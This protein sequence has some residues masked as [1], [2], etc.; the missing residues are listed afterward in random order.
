MLTGSR[1]LPRLSQARVALVGA[2]LTIGAT[3]VVSPAFAACG[4]VSTS[5]N[6]G[7]HSASA[8]SGVHTG[9]SSSSTHSASLSSCPTATTLN[10]T[11]AMAN[12]HVNSRVSYLAGGS[13]VAKTFTHLGSSKKVV[14]HSSSPTKN[15]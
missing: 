7:V 15:P 3:L 12:G 9:V 6:T 13:H 8:G 14:A 2:A 1:S 5:Q 11:H 10:G 4:V